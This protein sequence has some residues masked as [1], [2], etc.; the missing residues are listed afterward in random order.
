ML[1]AAE[2]QIGE[3][4]TQSAGSAAGL[5]R[6]LA[7]AQARIGELKREVD[8]A[9]NVRQFAANTEREIAQLERDLRDHKAKVTQITLERDR[10]ESQLRDLRDDSETTHRKVPSLTEE[11]PSQHA[12]YTQ[13]VSRASEL[14]QKNGKL[15]KDSPTLRRQ[16]AETEAARR[17]AGPRARGRA[18]E[19]R[20]RAAA[21]VRRAPQRRS[22]N[23][24]TRSA[25]TC[26]PP[27]TRPR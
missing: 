19:H 27:A 1:Q 13:L 22:R 12:R 3:A 20:Q 11:A 4:R 15:E 18:D 8:A 9:E 21:R 2:A 25:R 10:L 5:E 16:L 6:Q 23:R 24:S 7:A 17:R 14:E 26:A